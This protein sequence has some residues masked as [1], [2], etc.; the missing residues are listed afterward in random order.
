M[1]DKFKNF[2]FYGKNGRRIEFLTD[3]SLECTSNAEQI[4][5]DGKV[6]GASEAVETSTATINAAVCVAGKDSTQSLFDLFKSKEYATF[7]FGII[8]GRILSASMLVTSCKFD[9]NAAK[10]TTTLSCSM[11]GGEVS[12][13]G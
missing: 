1:G 12:K 10:G 2:S 9:S 5:V 8:D 13:K 7:T 6:A 3:G 11:I 4:V